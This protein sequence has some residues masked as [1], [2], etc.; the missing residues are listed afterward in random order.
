MTQ[1]ALAIVGAALAAGLLAGCGGGVHTPKLSSLPIVSGAHVL[2]RV[3]RC[4]KGSNAYCAIQ[5]VVVGP[6]FQSSRSL[7]LA[8]RD[9]LLR[10]GWI[11]ASPYTGVELA[12]ES[13]HHK[14]RVT[15]ATAVDDLQGWELNWIHP[16]WPIISTLDRSLFDRAPAMSVL[17]EVGSR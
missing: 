7:V 9:Q 2:E 16:P 6:R 4:N 8:E 14:L 10:E 13:P 11:G 3:N 1:R 12:D 5:L 17:L 15:Y